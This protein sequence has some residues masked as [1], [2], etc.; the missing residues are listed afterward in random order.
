MASPIDFIIIF[1]TAFGLN[2]IPFAGP[3]N[4]LIA[5]TVGVGLG[6]ANIATLVLVGVLIAFAAALAKGI[7]Y[8]VTFFVSGHLSQKRQERLNTDAKK[9]RRWAFP[10]LFVAAASPIPDE[11][12]V[13]PLGLMKYS[14]AKFFAAYFLGKLSITVAGVF[15]GGW[16]GDVA[17]SWFGLSVETTFIL[18]VIISVI[19]TII[20]TVIILKVDVEKLSQKYLHRKPT[21]PQENPYKPS[22]E[23]N[24]D[25][26]TCPL[27]EDT[28]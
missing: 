20:I 17:E 1:A 23:P 7:H 12:I 3:S 18:S 14:P 28:L 13:I 27:N 9:I 6:D 5:S 16:L 22:Q 21:A 11:P 4:L 25:E 15:L 8:M 24:T 19:L 10:L 2:L 26:S